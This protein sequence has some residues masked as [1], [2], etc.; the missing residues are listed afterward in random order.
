MSESLHSLIARDFNVR[1]RQEDERA[2]TAMTTAVAQIVPNDSSRLAMVIVNL[3][4]QIVF[5]RNRRPPSSSAGFSLGPGGGALI[6]HYRD[7][8]Y[9][10]GH[11]WFG[12]SAAGTSTLYV[13]E[14]L[15]EPDA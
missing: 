3:G 13:T 9:M 6:L 10:V 5:I 4:S 2:I 12:L 7:D 1:T 11:D 14:V 15:V 8:F